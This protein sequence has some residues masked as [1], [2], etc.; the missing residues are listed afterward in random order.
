M[1]TLDTPTPSYGRPPLQDGSGRTAIRTVIVIAAALLVLGGLAGLTVAAVGLGSTRVITE[2]RAL[3]TDLATL[4][5]DTGALPVAIRV[6]TD[7]AV[8]EPRVDL[9]FVT[10]SNPDEHT[11]AVGADGDA[12]R[13]S[14]GG[15]E[16]DYLSWARGGEI[17]VI[18]PPEIAADLA[19]TTNQQVG[20]LFADADVDRLVANTANGAV[21]LRG[22]AR[23]VEIHTDNGSIHT[24][25]PISVRESF[26]ATTSEGDIDVAFGSAPPETI[27]VSAVRGSV[28]VGLPAPGPYYVSA[29]SGLRHDADIEVEQTSDPTQAVASV[30]ATS[31]T[32][33]V[34]VQYADRDDH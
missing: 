24:R 27:E 4:E 22:S 9:R 14:L 30:T 23:D 20:V 18:L 10:M 15:R 6:R 16:S 3:P 11:L 32:G 29:Q 2:S 5:V 8:D 25:V 34:T 28:E 33:P 1:T 26:V 31:T 21:I 13:I 17:T 7:Q 19:V 12:V